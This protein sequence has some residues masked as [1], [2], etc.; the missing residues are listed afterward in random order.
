M[1]IIRAEHLGFNY[2]KY[3]DSN[4]S[5]ETV[6][7]V[8]NVD[9]E[10]EKGEFIAILGHNGSG[11]ST[12]AKHINA[13]LIPSEGTMWVDGINTSDFQIHETRHIIRILLEFF[14]GITQLWFLVDGFQ[15]G[16]ALLRAYD[17]AC[18]VRFSL[19]GRIGPYEENLRPVFIRPG[20]EDILFPFRCNRQAIPDGIDFLA[21]QF[22]FFAVP[23]YR[24]EFYFNAQA[25]GRFFCHIDIK[26][27]EFPA[28][29]VKSERREIVIETDDDFIFFS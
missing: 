21:V 15:T 18:Q 8:E 14:E 7:A 27:D 28:F 3:S 4:E 26:A 20:K 22:R 23:V 6:R 13:L 19:D 16:T 24:F 5:E 29:I 1:S 10:V 25:F 11:K 17:F 9:F 2:V 12:L